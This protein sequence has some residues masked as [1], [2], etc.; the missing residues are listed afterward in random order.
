MKYVEMVEDDEMLHVVT[1][2]DAESATHCC[3]PL[4]TAVQMAQD[5]NIGKYH[6]D[7]WMDISV[8]KAMDSKVLA[9]EVAWVSKNYEIVGFAK[10]IG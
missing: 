8:D 7:V 1:G 3:V 10:L 6:P 5:W 4:S 2:M 9:T